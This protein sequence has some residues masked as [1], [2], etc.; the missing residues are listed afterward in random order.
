MSHD[1][2]ADQDAFTARGM[3]AYAQAM[4]ELAG[5]KLEDLEPPDDDSD[6]PNDPEYQGRLEEQRFHR[7]Q[8]EDPAF[9]EAQATDT[10]KRI[11]ESL[12]AA[13]VSPDDP[14]LSEGKAAAKRIIESH[15][16][17]P[18]GLTTE[19]A[20]AMGA[21]AARH[22][23]HTRFT[24][25]AALAESER[26]GVE[27]SSCYQRSADD[28]MPALQA[29]AAIRPHVNAPADDQAAGDY[30]A[31]KACLAA[32]HDRLHVIRAVCVHGEYGTRGYDYA[33]QIVKAADNAS[34]PK[35]KPA[36]TPSRSPGP[37]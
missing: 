27:R 15:T 35:T 1:D 33:Q 28:T 3:L 36:Q 13:G 19:G 14:P 34:H 31:A 18:N 22:S 20:G 8:E 10:E 25:S 37:R 7:L 30:A 17:A 24:V 5:T 29:Y 9:L 11:G 6:D 16:C 4:A 12:A 2:N 23:G 21:L 32:G 26:V